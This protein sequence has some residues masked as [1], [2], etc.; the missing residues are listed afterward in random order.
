MGIR[1]ADV[2]NHAFYGIHKITF[3]DKELQQFK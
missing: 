1:L 3:V 2:R